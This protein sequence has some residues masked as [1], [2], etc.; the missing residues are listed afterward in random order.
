MLFLS[1]NIARLSKSFIEYYLA[2]FPKITFEPVPV[3]SS[4]IDPVARQNVLFS[5]V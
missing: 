5:P 4:L 1:Q 3:S 2:Q